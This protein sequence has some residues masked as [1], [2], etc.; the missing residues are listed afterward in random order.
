MNKLTE[1]ARYR[2]FKVDT[3]NSTDKKPN[4]VKITDLR[5]SKSVILN[6]GAVHNSLADLLIS[7][8]ESKGID[9]EAQTWA[10]DKNGVHLYGIYLTEDFTNQIK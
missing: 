1:V 10:E 5:Y 3:L 9:I 4:R 7:F 6:Y 2:A 8:F